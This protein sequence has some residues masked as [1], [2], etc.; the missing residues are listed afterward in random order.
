MKTGLKRWVMMVIG[1][2]LTGCMTWV[3]LAADSAQWSSQLKAGDTV[4][5]TLR[6]G[7]QQQLTLDGI[8]QTA[9]RGGGQRIAFAD[10]QQLSRQQIDGS[11]TT[12]LV[13]GITVVAVAASSGGSDDDDDGGG[14]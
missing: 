9:L 13:V 10:I 7:R 5:A 11:K 3:P 12:W 14:Y 8:E 6:D 4:L 2:L 1:A